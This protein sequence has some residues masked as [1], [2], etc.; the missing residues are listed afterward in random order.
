MI[1]QKQ[2]A[3]DFS[4]FRHGCC[5]HFSLHACLQRTSYT[6]Q[7]RLYNATALFCKIINYGV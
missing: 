6:A 5:L 4:T 7:R 3:L 2:W 1:R